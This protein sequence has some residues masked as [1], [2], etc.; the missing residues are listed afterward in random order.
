MKVTVG[1]LPDEGYQSDRV[2]IKTFGSNDVIHLQK[3]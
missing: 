3:S 1:L 2:V